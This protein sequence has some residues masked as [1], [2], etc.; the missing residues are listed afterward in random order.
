MEKTLFEETKEFKNQYLLE[1][2]DY[3]LDVILNKSKKRKPNNKFS[4]AF[5]QGSQ[6]IKDKINYYFL[7]SF[8]I[9]SILAVTVIDNS[10]I[11]IAV[12]LPFFLSIFIYCL[13][14]FGIDIRKHFH[15][16]YYMRLSK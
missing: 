10:R 11:K 2:R 4:S 5:E 14:F 7:V 8:V 15:K 6:P 13:S 3:S 16:R 12:L 1:D 9:I